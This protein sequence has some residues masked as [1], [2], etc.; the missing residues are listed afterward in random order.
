M[1]II[2]KEMLERPRKHLSQKQD[3][4]VSS[5]NKKDHRQHRFPLPNTHQ[6]LLQK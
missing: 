2:Y 4:I 6:A 1:H 3:G 5:V